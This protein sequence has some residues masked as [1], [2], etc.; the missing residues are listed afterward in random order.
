[1]SLSG[2]VDLQFIAA[3]ERFSEQLTGTVVLDGK[4]NKLTPRAG[5]FICCGEGPG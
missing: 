2:P 1:M 3:R 5:L 4:Y